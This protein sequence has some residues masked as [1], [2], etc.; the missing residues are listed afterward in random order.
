MGMDTTQEDDLGLL[1]IEE[2]DERAEVLFEMLRG[3]APNRSRVTRARHLSTYVADAA[4]PISV[5]LLSAGARA[6]MERFFAVRTLLPELPVVVLFDD[7]GDALALRIVEA[8]AEDCLFRREVTD[9]VIL[10]RAL[11]YAVERHRLRAEVERGARSLRAREEMFRRVV[12]SQ[13]D[14]VVIV[15]ALRHVRFANPAAERL[16]GERADFLTGQ[17]LALPIEPGRTTTTRSAEGDRLLEIRAVL[18]EWESRP[19][20]LAS[21]RDITESVRSELEVLRASQYEMLGVLAG[22]I[23]HDLNNFL[24]CLCLN[25]HFALQV[26]RDNPRLHEILV[27]MQKALPRASELTQQLLTFAKGGSPVRGDASLADIIRDTTS[28]ALRGSNV[29][30]ELSIPDGLWTARVDTGPLSQILNNLVVNAHQAMPQGGTLRVQARN[31]TVPLNEPLPGTHELRDGPYIHVRV[32]DQGHGIAPA[33]LERIFEPYF[34]TRSEGNG[35]G[36]AI[37]RSILQALGGHITAESSPAGSVFHVYVPAVG[38]PVDPRTTGDD[39]PR[40]LFMDDEESICRVVARIL[41]DAAVD[42]VFARDGFEALE[43][44]ERAKA[45]GR[46]FDVAILDVTVPGGMGAEATL[47]RLRSVDPTLKVLVSS[48]SLRDPVMLNPGK[49]GFQGSIGKPYNVTDLTAGLRSLGLPV[50]GLDGGGADRAPQ[51]SERA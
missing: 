6:A 38:G 16:L 3:A 8:G 24:T 4:A 35:L 17:H 18:I 9:G 36:L 7:E 21:L 12:E 2:S 13:A 10:W 19:A 31:V 51:V 28:F 43:K 42:V 44:M 32:Q 25:V 34:T 48:A 27:D 41:D 26:G 46:P 11:R 39:R 33:I 23:A 1:V 49:H 50:G 40:V 22:G 15:D 45:A 47:P 14:A 30:C 37:C 29:C 20:V 5:V